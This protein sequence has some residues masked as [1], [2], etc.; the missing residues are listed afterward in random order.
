VQQPF[1]WTGR[2]YDRATGLY[3]L[4]A[5]EYDPNAARFMQEDP[6]WLKAGDHNVYRYVAN[7]PMKY[8]DPSGMML[9]EYGC[10]AQFAQGPRDKPEDDICGW[11]GDGISN[12]KA[13]G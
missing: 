3:H 4:R 8:T 11:D 2:E 1:G 5:R 9:I 13:P 12:R 7:N 10:M 6:I